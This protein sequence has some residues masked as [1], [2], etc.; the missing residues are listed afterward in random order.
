MSDVVRAK[1]FVVVDDEGRERARLGMDRDQVGLDLVG[2]GD[3]QASVTL[4]LGAGGD[5]RLKLARLEQVIDFHIS[6]HNISVKLSTEGE[7]KSGCGLTVDR[8]GAWLVAETNNEVGVR[9]FCRNDGTATSVWLSETSQQDGETCIRT[10][11]IRPDPQAD[12]TTAWRT[13]R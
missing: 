13:K 2:L 9:A 10:R 8:A 5:V 11:F 12:Q 7:T 3:N 6:E 4:R 1:S